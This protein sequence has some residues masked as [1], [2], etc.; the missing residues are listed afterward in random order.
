M[1]GVRTIPTMYLFDQ[2]GAIVQKYVGIVPEEMME[3]DIKKA[4]GK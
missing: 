2:E 4:L 3:T 1:G